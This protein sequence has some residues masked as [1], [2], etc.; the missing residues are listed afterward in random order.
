MVQSRDLAACLQLS[1]GQECGDE[2]AGH[3]DSGMQGGSHTKHLSLSQTK[4]PKK[5]DKPIA[6]GESR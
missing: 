5:L 4:G 6:G 1:P 3:D 2:T